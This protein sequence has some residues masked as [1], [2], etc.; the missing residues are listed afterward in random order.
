LGDF[1]QCISFSLRA[2][3]TEA[4]KFG[5][6]K[7]ISS[8]LDLDTARG[9]DASFTEGSILQRNQEAKTSPSPEAVK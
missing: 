6:V 4:L 8:A 1:V 5:V 9:A 3:P 7:V 2:S